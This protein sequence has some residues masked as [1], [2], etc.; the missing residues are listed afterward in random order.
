M[1]TIGL[2]LTCVESIQLNCLHHLSEIR[3]RDALLKAV[4]T[5]LNIFS[6]PK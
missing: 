6:E 3:R 5:E 2:L 4:N 1:I